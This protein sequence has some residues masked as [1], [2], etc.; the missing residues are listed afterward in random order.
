MALRRAG[1]APPV[2]ALVALAGLLPGASPAAAAG[3][4][5]DYVLHCQGCHRPDG[6]ETPGSTPALAGQVARFLHVPGG[7]AFLGRVPGVA[8]A[9]LGDPAL[10]ALLNWMVQRFDPAHMPADFVPYGADEVRAL[11]S[12]PLVDVDGARRRLTDAIARLP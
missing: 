6:E 3:P 12:D 11:R 5:Q 1:S 8:Q 7:R 4:E 9:P 10:A 2:A